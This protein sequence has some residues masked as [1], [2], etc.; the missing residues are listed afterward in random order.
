M[1]GV[2]ST[3]W[4]WLASD[5]RMRLRMQRERALKSRITLTPPA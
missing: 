5:R 2:G 4:M 1:G 3:A